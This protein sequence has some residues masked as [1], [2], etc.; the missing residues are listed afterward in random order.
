MLRNHDE[1]TVDLVKKTN[2]S[3]HVVVKVNNHPP[4]PPWLLSSIYGS[5]DFNTRKLLWE[6]LELIA[7]NNHLH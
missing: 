6:E 1:V 2:Q 5:P 4:T 3:I 7:T